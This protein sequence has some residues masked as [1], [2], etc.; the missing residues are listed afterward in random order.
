MTAGIHLTADREVDAPQER[1]FGLFGTGQAAGWLFDAQ[2]DRLAVGAVVTVSVPL[3]GPAVAPVDLLGRIAAV[4][5][6]RRIDIV[7]E[8]PWRGRLRVNIDR[9]DVARCR[10]RLV[11]EL[12]ESGLAWLMRRRGAVVEEPG[13]PRD[14]V[15]GLLTSKS[16]PGGVFAAAAENLAAMAVAEVNADGGIGGRPLRLVVGDDATD[17]GT[18]VLEA[19]R[20]VGAGCRTI[21][22]ATTSATFVRVAAALADGVLLVQPVMNEGG[23][24]A[25]LRVQLGERPHDQLRAAARTVMEVAGGRRWF[26]AGNDYCWPRHVHTA[27]RQVVAEQAGVVVGEAFAPLGGRDFGPLV[28]RLIA[29]RP[30]VV[31]SSFVGADLVAFERQC[32]ARGVR[33]RSRSLALALDEPTR[34]RIGDEACV[35]LW[36]VSGY[37]EEVEGAA[38][39]DFLHRYRDSFG[40]LA[41]PVSSISQSV[42][43]SVH[44]YAA[45]AR[46]AGGGDPS[47]VGRALREERSDLPRGT[48]PTVADARA[49][50]GL[51]LAEA[52]AG[53]FAV[54][55]GDQR[56]SVR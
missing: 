19:R 50:R 38:N 23:L 25:P 18:G 40:A 39:G 22:V 8:Q 26:L 51:Y 12:D 14:H 36:G 55:P 4:S 9:V 15:L 56:V 48:L 1:V 54:R 33:D 24:D 44:R 6:P 16:G 21:V 10:V 17:P 3:G 31:L 35:G 37:F 11:A 5:A 20:L 29:A 32:H 2:C 43:E 34:E 7:H 27:A 49:G 28:D 41:T 53:G 46:R 45:A 42:Y 47:D 30:D 52:V 13:G